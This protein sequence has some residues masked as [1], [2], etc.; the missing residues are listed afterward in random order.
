MVRAATRP[1]SAAVYAS[2]S[3]CSTIV[4]DSLYAA[5]VRQQRVAVLMSPDGFARHV[6]L[7][8]NRDYSCYIAIKEDGKDEFFDDYPVGV[9][10]FEH[11]GGGSYREVPLQ[12]PL[13]VRGPRKRVL[14]S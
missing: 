14:D 7:P 8:T 13:P 10:V 5:P 11:T 12:V 6:S 9:R 4:I 1:G 3:T 2:F